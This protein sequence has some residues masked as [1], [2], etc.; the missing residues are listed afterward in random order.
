[1]VLLLALV[2]DGQA[3][4]AHDIEELVLSAG[5]DDT[6]KARFIP[7]LSQRGVAGNL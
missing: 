1:V 5:S 7:P 3:I 4:N 6:S 2:P